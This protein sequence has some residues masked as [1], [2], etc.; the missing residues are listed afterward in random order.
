[1][2]PWLRRALLPSFRRLEARH[3]RLSYLFVELTRACNLACRHCGSDC[4]RDATAPPLPREAVLRALEGIAAAQ[5]PNG[6]MVVLSGG[7]PLCY[8]GVFDLGAAIHRLGFPWGMVTNGLAWGPE[9]FAAAKAASMA[10]VTVSLDGFEEDHDWLRGREGSFRRALA[11]LRGL[12]ADPFWQALDVVTCVNPR[13]LPRLEAFRTFLMEAGLKHWRIF[14]I[15]PIG[16]A[17][18]DPA[19]LLAPEE[20]RALMEMIEGFRTQG[21]LDVVYAESGYL[22]RFE[23]RVR[24]QPYFCRAGINIGGIMVD[25][26]ILACPNIDRRFA[27]GNIHQDAFMD[28]WNTRFRPFRDRRWMRKGDCSACGEW[29]LCEGNAFHLWEPGGRAPKVCHHRRFG[30]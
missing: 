25:G 20:F 13:N 19:L 24:D 3:H 2:R 1:M 23:C 21:G 6:V 4:T 14:T 5:D 9:A 27:Q 28:V 15:D 29:G 12:L 26:A 11:T 8:P 18:E 30:L 22:G 7:E 10:S 16:R 17:A